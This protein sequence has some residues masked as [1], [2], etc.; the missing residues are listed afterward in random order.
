M[1]KKEVR[2][3]D[4]IT[5][6][7]VRVIGADGSQVGVIT[8]EEAKQAALEAGLDLV[9]IVPNSTPPVCKIIDYGKYKY[10]LSKKEKIIKKRQHVIHVKEIRLS[11]KI[12]EHDFN[13]KLKHARK[14]LEQGN[15]VK[16]NVFFKGRQITH[17]EFGKDLLNKFTAELEDIAKLENRPRIEGRNMVAMYVKK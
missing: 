9:E 10:E 16:V 4:Q 12:E 6:P 8:I 3:N 14:F 2:I 1:K 13:F 5:S 17:L 15:K 7:S 11:P